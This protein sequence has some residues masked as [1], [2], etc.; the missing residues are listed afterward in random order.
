MSYDLSHI[1]KLLEDTQQSDEKFTTCLGQFIE[2]MKTNPLMCAE[3]VGDNSI[4]RFLSCLFVPIIKHQPICREDFQFEPIHRESLQ[5]LT[6]LCLIHPKYRDLIVRIAPFDA[7]MKTYFMVPFNA[8]HSDASLIFQFFSLT[9]STRSLQSVEIAPDSF[10]RFFKVFFALLNNCDQ[11]VLVWV[12]SSMASFLINSTSALN[13]LKTYPEFLLLRT[14]LAALLS[15]ENQR[16]MLASLALLVILFPTDVLPDTAMSIAINGLCATS[17][18]QMG[19]ILSTWI[20]FETI[21]QVPLTKEMIFTLVESSVK[22]RS[23]TYWI[24]E[25]LSELH[26]CHPILC[27]VFSD[28]GIAD[29]LVEYLSEKTDGCVAVAGSRMVMKVGQN[30]PVSERIV[31]KLV[32]SLVS[33]ATPNEKKL[34]NVILLRM[35]LSTDASNKILQNY[36]NEIFFE[37]RRALEL[38][39]IELSLHLFNFLS[40]NASLK[41]WSKKMS[42]VVA[43]GKVTMMIM[44][45]LVSLPIKEHTELAITAMTVIASGMKSHAV[46]SPM[47]TTLVKAWEFHAD[48]TRQREYQRKKER[49]Q[50]EERHRMDIQA[51]EV[52]RDLA[53]QEIV[54]VQREMREQEQTVSNLHNQLE[55]KSKEIATLNNQMQLQK[56]KNDDLASENERLRS[57]IAQ[58]EAS[59]RDE[60]TSNQTNLSKLKERFNAERQRSSSELAQVRE[61][62]SKLQSVSKTE[63]DLIERQKSTIAKLQKKLAATKRKLNAK[64]IIT[65]RPSTPVTAPAPQVELPTKKPKRK[66]PE[67]DESIPCLEEKKPSVRIFFRDGSLRHGLAE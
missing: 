39:Q 2:G 13:I 29:K 27:D 12:L 51:I 52:E 42:E 36:S 62:L 5:F 41:N 25:L 1:C 43:D 66:K 23:N 64:D 33:R 45:V 55:A 47:L 31:E 53:E 4:D 34:A 26:E 37:M 14:K 20:I 9:C 8:S 40:E 50:M 30:I 22:N 7:L 56:Q 48:Q 19:Q 17:D 60:K 67:D 54:S 28:H 11:K 65:E 58:L 32:K 6:T 46:T 44:E 24:Y 18:F 35:T 49:A 3:L 61:S 57:R 63:K 21:D 10:D 59:I 15:P 38:R 16:V